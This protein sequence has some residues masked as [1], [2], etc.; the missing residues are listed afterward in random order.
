MLTTPLT[1]VRQP[2][3]RLGEVAADLLLRAAG[4][5]AP[6]AQQVQ[7]QPELVVR[8]SSGP[9]RAPASARHAPSGASATDPHPSP[10]RDE[11]PMTLQVAI[12]GTGAV[13]HHHAQALEA[14]PRVRLVAVADRS[15]DRAAAFAERYGVPGRFGSMD[16]LL[17]GGALDVVHLCTPPDAHREQALAAFAAGRARRVREAAGA[18]PRR[19]GRHAVGRR[20]RRAGVRDRLPAAHRDGR[21]ARPRAAD[22]R[23]ARPSAA[24]AVPDAVAPRRRLLRR[25]LARHVGRRG[26][27]HDRWATAS[28]RWTCSRTC[29]ATGPRSTRGCSGSPATSRWRTSR[30]RPSASRRVRSRSRCRACCRPASRASSGSTPSGPRSRSST[31]TGTAARAGASPRHPA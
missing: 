7:F 30:R 28:T 1:S 6:P 13:A 10:R 5:D 22:L 19:A 14:D 16:E 26:R 11:H 4:P 29:S 20:R 23:R 15:P 18:V 27:R 3:H 17:A 31:S 9:P 25:R 21:G 8:A 24:R 2:T 12:V